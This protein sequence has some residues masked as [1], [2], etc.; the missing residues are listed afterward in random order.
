MLDLSLR[1]SL[2]PLRRAVG[3]SSI[4]CVHAMT[5]HSQGSCQA[6][7]EHGRDSGAWPLVPKEGPQRSSLA[8]TL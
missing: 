7:T 1:K 8:E 2:H 5:M 3:A 6:V 4:F